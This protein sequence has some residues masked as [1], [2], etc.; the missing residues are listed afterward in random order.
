[1]FPARLLGLETEYGIHVEG[2][3]AADLLDEARAVVRAYAGT[4]AGPWDYRCEDPRRDLRGFRVDQL[5]S[6]PQDAL[7][8][9]PGRPAVSHEEQRSDRVLTNG[10]RLYNDHGHPEYATPEC[11]TLRDLV[12]HDRAGERIVLACARR[13]S[14]ETG[15]HIQIYKNNT[16][17][18][19]MS[20]GCHEDYLVPRDVPFERL[21]AA[22]VPFFVTRTIFTG[23]GKVGVETDGPWPETPYQLSQ[24]ADFFTEEASVDTLHRRPLLNTRDEPHA[25]PQRY[26][27]LHVICG[28]ANLSEFATALKVGS[29]SLVLALCELGWQPL[30]RVRRP[31]EAIRRLSRDPEY[32]WLVE[33]E[34]GRTMR[35]TDLQRLYLSEAR[36]CFAGADAETDGILAEWA[37][38]LDDLDANPLS[39]ADRLDW[40]AKR[41]LLETYL[42]AE[43]L[44]WEG[45]LLRSLDLEYHNIDPDYGLHAAL[46]EEG[47]LRRVVEETD[48]QSALVQPPA[49]TRAYVRGDC[50]RRFGT[51]VQRIGWGRIGLRVEERTH[52][53]DLRA[54]V[55]GKVVHLN[56]RLPEAATLAEWIELVRGGK[57]DAG[58]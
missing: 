30:F 34:D 17:F 13:R 43:H 14:Q 10:A 5:A 19:G 41:V 23:A 29:T 16:D 25:D 55:D 37:R 21:H 20:Y 2:K 39:T 1:M 57:K 52:W 54:L 26:L 36:R 32:R 12:A 40:A 56:R 18:H 38:V 33:R 35:A 9:H 45:E 47:R 53:V 4:C 22:L 44:S 15:S 51:A 50:V 6:N 42:E 27:R 24:R 3:G 58:N 28:D 48:I 46:V 49:D 31:T 7:Y 11:L 8:D